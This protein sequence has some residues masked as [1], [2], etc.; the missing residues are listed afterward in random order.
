MKNN[1]L[2]R[3]RFHGFLAL[4]LTSVFCP[5]GFAQGDKKTAYAILLDNTG[6]LRNQFPQVEAFGKGLVHRTCR[7]GP[8]SLFNFMSEGIGRGSRA[9]VT[10]GAEWTQDENVL[11]KHI[12]DIYVQGGQTTLRDAIYFMAEKLNAKVDADKNAFASKVIIMVTDGEDRVSAVNEQK[13]IKMLR[14]RGVAVYAVGLLG[15]LES[16]N[17][18]IRKSPRARAEDFLNKVAKETGGGVIFPRTGDTN[19][20]ALLGKLLP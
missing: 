2:A 19:V 17:I 5:S 14:D 13:L 4:L 6:S 11:D 15:E 18:P 10:T 9:I 1:M 16:E 7:R 3:T 12:D 8:I 20:D